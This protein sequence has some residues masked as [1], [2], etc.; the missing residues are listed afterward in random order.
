MPCKTKLSKEWVD[1]VYRRLASATG[2]PFQ[3]VD[4]EDS[5]PISADG[6]LEFCWTTP[7]QK[8]DTKFGTVEINLPEDPGLDRSFLAVTEIGEIVGE[9]VGR[10]I[11]DSLSLQ[12][13]T[14][15]VETLVELGS[16]K[17]EEENISEVISQLLAGTS[18]LADLRTTSFF[19]FDPSANRLKLRS[20]VNPDECEIP[21]PNR[22]LC[23]AQFDLQ[24]FSSRYS[25]VKRKSH[26]EWLPKNSEWGI[27][28]PVQTPAGP[29]GTIW[30]FDRRQMEIDERQIHILE[31][32]ATQLGSLL[33]RFVLRQESDDRF[34]LKQ[35]LQAASEGDPYETNAPQLERMGIDYSLQCTS[36][37]ELGGDLCEVSPLDDSRVMIVVGDASG[38]SIPAALVMSTLRGALH[39]IANCSEIDFS[40]TEKIMQILN[41][42]LCETTLTQQ[43]MSL[44][45]GVWDT[46]TDR[47][48]YTNAGHPP[49]LVFRNDR[50]DQLESHGMLLGIL[51]SAEYAQSIVDL[52]TDD[53]FVAFSDG[54]SEAMSHHRRQFRQDGVID[55]L[56]NITDRSAGEMGVVVWDKLHKHVAGAGE[57][58]DRSLLIMKYASEISKTA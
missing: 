22:K 14:E 13:R 3:F 36:R 29:L 26:P 4:V 37:F 49:P 46:Q 35:D 11:G 5:R 55:A 12:S 27:C 8:E 23:D 48:A 9:L 1:S 32:F 16:L 10:C 38:D 54:I 45:F 18:K 58:D 33:E 52:N 44:F 19:L 56:E 53:V 41:C 20:S 57:G 15:E 42:A 17:S 28:V 50:T 25:V 34:R 39:A 47:L 31:S 24:A 40:R 30:A 2:W 7:I 6:S 43:F 51:D 21:F